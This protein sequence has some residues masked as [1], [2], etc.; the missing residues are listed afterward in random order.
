MHTSKSIARIVSISAIAILTTTAPA[1]AVPNNNSDTSGTNT[2][3]QVD[4]LYGFQALLNQPGINSIL[5]KVL[6]TINRILSNNQRAQAVR[7]I[8]LDAAKAVESFTAQVG[9]DPQHISSNKLSNLLLPRS[10]NA[11]TASRTA[12]QISRQERTTYSYSTPNNALISPETRKALSTLSG[13]LQD[14]EKGLWAYGN[15]LDKA[16]EAS[17]QGLLK[18]LNAA[19]KSC[20]ANPS[21]CGQFNDL[22]ADTSNFVRDLKEF[23]TILHNEVQKARIY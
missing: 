13:Y 14:M 22:V 4:L 19:N 1:I 3:G 16:V 12:Q 17:A 23:E 10:L 9:N 2:N 5:Q 18:D 11:G 6:K 7:T 20:Q 15:D 21:S 8:E